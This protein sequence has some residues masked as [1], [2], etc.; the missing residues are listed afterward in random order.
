LTRW[1]NFGYIKRKASQ[2]DAINQVDEVR[3]LSMKEMQALF[4]EANI[5]T[6]YWLGMVKSISAYIISA[7]IDDR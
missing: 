5:Y 6:E 2:K 1:G 3:L 4:P 7:E